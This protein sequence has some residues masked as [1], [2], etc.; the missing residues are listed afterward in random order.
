MFSAQSHSSSVSEH[1]YSCNDFSHQNPKSKVQNKKHT[2]KN[3]TCFLPFSPFYCF[4]TPELQIETL[5]RHQT[6]SSK[7]PNYNKYTYK[8][9]VCYNI[10]T[11]LR[12]KRTIYVHLKF[13]VWNLN[14]SQ[15][16]VLRKMKVTLSQ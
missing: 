3:K 2:C 8:F 13:G 1:L 9:S 10:R 7:I 16:S 14:E 6:P 5:T 11:V 4:F 15:F 12:F